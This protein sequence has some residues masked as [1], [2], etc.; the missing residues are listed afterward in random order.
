[1]GGLDDQELGVD[2]RFSSRVSVRVV[3]QSCPGSAIGLV[4]CKSI[5]GTKLPILL[6]YIG[7]ICRWR[8]LQIGVVVPW[9]YHRALLG[10]LFETELIEVQM[11]AFGR[12]DVASLRGMLGNDRLAESAVLA[13]AVSSGGSARVR[14]ATPQFDP[15]KGTA[16]ETK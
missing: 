16:D 6:F 7:D 1:M 5:Q 9:S 13:E 4:F 8:Q 10:L 15:R 3:F 11:F 14:A 12:I 2:L